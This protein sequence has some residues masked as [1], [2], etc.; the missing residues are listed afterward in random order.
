MLRRGCSDRRGFAGI[1][2]WCFGHRS[3]NSLA[4]HRHIFGDLTHTVTHDIGNMP[5]K[6]ARKVVLFTID[7]NLVD[8]S[9]RILR[10]VFHFNHNMQSV[11]I[12]ERPLLCIVLRAM[13]VVLCDVREDFLQETRRMEMDVLVVPKVFNSVST[14]RKVAK[15]VLRILGLH[16]AGEIYNGLYLVADDN[17]GIVGRL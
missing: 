9:Q 15:V 13:N 2:V 11:S 17:D 7:E 14:S 6:R 5:E 4:R 1:A 8:D 16:S 12:G 3:S 10:V